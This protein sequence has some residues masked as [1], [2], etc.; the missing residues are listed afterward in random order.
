MIILDIN[1]YAIAVN[2]TVIG[3]KSWNFAV[4]KFF[5][6]LYIYDGR[7]WIVMVVFWSV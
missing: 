3:Y 4:K 7:H 6:V 5:F 1:R 2:K